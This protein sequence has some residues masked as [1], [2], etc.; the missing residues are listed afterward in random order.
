MADLFKKIVDCAEEK[1]EC[2]VNYFTT[3][4]DG[5]SKKGH[6][7]LGKWHTWLLAPECWAHQ[8][9]SPWLR[10]CRLTTKSFSNS[11]NSLSEIISKTIR[12]HKILLDKQQIQLDGLIAMERSR[13]YLIQPRKQSALIEL[14]S[15][16]YNLSHATFSH[17][18]APHL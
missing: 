15:F 3:D 7:I 6:Q 14:L 10:F 17:S 16:V 18:N 1:Y 8:V 5:G 9:N 13:K 12:W 2:R 4:C 11:S